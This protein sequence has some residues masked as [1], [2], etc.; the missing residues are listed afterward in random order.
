ME[1]VAKGHLVS[2]MDHEEGQRT[3]ELVDDPMQIPR[4]IT[5]G[6]NPQLYDE[7]PDVFCGS[8]FPPTSF[9]IETILHVPFS[10]AVLLRLS[11]ISPQPSL[12]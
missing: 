7:L 2:I 10:K 4:K 9:S 11:P 8:F 12:E 3:E 6:W 1:V 5:Q